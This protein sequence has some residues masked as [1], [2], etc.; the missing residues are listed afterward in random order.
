[1]ASHGRSGR[2]RG[3]ARA[4]PAADTS[5]RPLPTG[6]VETVDYHTGG[7]PFR[8]VTSGI[9][10]IPG[11]TILAKRRHAQAHLDDVRR[12]DTGADLG[13]L[14]FHN[15]GFSTACGHGTI[16]LVTWALESGVLAAHEPET[17]VV[18]D[19]PSGRLETWARV[20]DG[21]IRAVRFRNVPAF[22]HSPGV[23]FG[24]AFYASVEERV[25][26]REL[27]RLIEVGRRIKAELDAEREIVHPLEPELHGVYGVVF[28]E[29]VADGPPLV[30]RN[31]TVFADGEVDRSPCGSG[32]SA[33][34][35]LLAAEGQLD[36]GGELL[37]R[38]IVGSEFRARIVGQAEVAGLQAVVT[39]VEGTAHRTG[40]HE[41]VL[42]PDDELGLGFLL[43]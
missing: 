3:Q 36:V 23:A 9:G 11:E 41:F 22:V 42:E 30:Q 37:H 2:G 31:V 1:M 20:E 25:E 17:R 32:T 29:H 21:D 7:E 4:T 16:A 13:V 35:A 34:L 26:P 24:G 27:P 14:F 18:V 19:V 43:R 38:S 12:Q 28:W 6:P 15:E 40:K 33:R 8:I 10:P 39:E 5:P